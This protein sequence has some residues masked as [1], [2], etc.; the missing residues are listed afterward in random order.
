MVGNNYEEI[1]SLDKNLI[2]K[3]RGKVKIQIGKKCFDLIDENGNLAIK[4][5]SDNEE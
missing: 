1:G 5:S 3:T 2:L 4:I